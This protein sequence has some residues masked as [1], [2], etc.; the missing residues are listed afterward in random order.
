LKKHKLRDVIS[1]LVVGAVPSLIGLRQA[2]RFSAER[3]AD[4]LSAYAEGR[5]IPADVR[6]RLR[7]KHFHRTKEDVRAMVH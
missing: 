3:E 4:I 6:R 7:R 5:P 1:G 2:N